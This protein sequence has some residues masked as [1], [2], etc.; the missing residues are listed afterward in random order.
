MYLY[1]TNILSELRKKRINPQAEKFITSVNENNQ[2]V[3]IS[4][5][6]IGEIVKGIEVLK[7]R[8][9][10]V[11][12]G[13]IQ[14]WYETITADFITNTIP[15]DNACARV[16]GRLVAHNNAHNSVDLQIAA[17]AI[18]HDLI[19]VTRNTKDIATTGVT[20]INPFE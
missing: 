11:Q 2:Q 6:T 13:H 7:K 17:T 12:A 18:V 4:S 16:W 20:F 14:A 8:N 5:L 3:F 1:D 15:F 10:N 19:L 9:D